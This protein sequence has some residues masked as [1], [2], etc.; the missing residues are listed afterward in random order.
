LLSHPKT[1]V[2][3][4]QEELVVAWGLIHCN[5]SN[6]SA[7]AGLGLFSAS[8]ISSLLAIRAE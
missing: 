2:E 6:D 4:G 1:V 8:A 5:V 7:A 3:P